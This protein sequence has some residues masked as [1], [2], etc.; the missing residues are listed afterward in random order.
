MRI[1]FGFEVVSKDSQQSVWQYV[2][3]NRGGL[4][5]EFPD[6]GPDLCDATLRMQ[7]LA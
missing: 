6:S 5:N 1:Q 7:A 2:C 3:Q 4:V